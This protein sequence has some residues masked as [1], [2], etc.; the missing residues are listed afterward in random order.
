MLMSLQE[1]II[2]L[3]KTIKG[4]I[5]VVAEQVD[6]KGSK[7]NVNKDGRENN[8]IKS[9]KSYSQLFAESV[10]PYSIQGCCCK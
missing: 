2:I 1:K 3:T 5:Y 8:N 4:E 6:A 9:A 7:N 10:E